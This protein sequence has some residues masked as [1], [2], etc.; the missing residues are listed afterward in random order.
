MLQGIFYL[1][2]VGSSWSLVGII[3]GHAPKHDIDT[4]VIQLA[5]A[6]VPFTVSLLLFLTN[7][8]PM[9]TC[10]L[11]TG[12]Q[13]ALIFAM[14]GVLGFILLQLMA[15]TMQRGPNGI[16]WAII[17]SG[18]IFPF[19]MGIV[20]FDVPLSFT[21]GAGLLAILAALLLFALA[22]HRGLSATAPWLGLS[23]LAFLI[24]GTQQMLN[25]LPS[26]IPEMRDG[27]THYFRAFSVACGG[28]LAFTVRNVLLQ[29]LA[30]FRARF[31]N[32]IRKPL[33]WKYV[34]IKQGFGLISAYFLLYRGMDRLSAAG[35]G[36]VSYPLLVGSCIVAFTLYS[37][38]ILKERT[39]LAQYAGLV[40]CLVGIVA[41]CLP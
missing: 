9:F 34:V 22:K 1:V 2:L 36:S 14:V 13:A 12:L 16:V 35:I 30:G 7:T 27:V 33:F 8:V 17:Q 4:G 6:L 15:C 26:Y 37:I 32:S 5:S 3:M 18:L 38:F 19:M 10:A 11:S 31:N 23:L 24:C 29:K 39:G 40:L 21:R 20:F 41:I 28:I 25:N